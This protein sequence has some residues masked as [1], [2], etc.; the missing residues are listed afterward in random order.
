[1]NSDSEGEGAGNNAL[2]HG[3]MIRSR[4]HALGPGY[5][6][7]FDYGGYPADE[8]CTVQLSFQSRVRSGPL[9]QL[10]GIL[11]VQKLVELED[12]VAEAPLGLVTEE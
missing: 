4:V 8:H 10:T 12:S 9:F 3:L 5:P 1:V 11:G 7:E 2:P 6:Q